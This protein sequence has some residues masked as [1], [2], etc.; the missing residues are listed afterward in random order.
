MYYLG[1]F[2]CG[3]DVNELLPVSGD[4]FTE[5]FVKISH[6]TKEG[7]FLALSPINKSKYKRYL[8][9]VLQTNRRYRSRDQ[10]QSW[11]IAYLERESCSV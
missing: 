6:L 1:V 2:V 8:K 7:E 9:S 10:R 5:A 3:C 11:I 4:S